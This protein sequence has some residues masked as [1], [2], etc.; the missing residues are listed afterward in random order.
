MS[1]PTLAICYDY[2]HALE[3]AF[4]AV[5][6]AALPDVPVYI[7]GDADNESQQSRP[8]F[9]FHCQGGAATDHRSTH[10]DIY[11]CDSFTGT[12]SCLVVTKADFIEHRAW[13]AMARGILGAIETTLTQEA[14]AGDAVMPYH[15]LNRC[16]ES[17]SSLEIQTEEGAMVSTCNYEIHF[18][19]R[20]TAWPEA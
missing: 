2:E 8:R 13:R 17:G 16:V 3:A 18:N 15:S 10:S 7:P 6:V 4:K 19:I 9:Q 5:F 11:R 1:A 20:S 14:A 12:M